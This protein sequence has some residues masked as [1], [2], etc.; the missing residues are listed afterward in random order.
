MW[1]VNETTCLRVDQR[2]GFVEWLA[3]H[4]EIACIGSNFNDLENYLA[5][6]FE[7]LPPDKIINELLLFL[8]EISWWRRKS[9]EEICKMNSSSRHIK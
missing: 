2:N 9:P 7:G 3:A 1:V 5:A 4:C 8:A 6:W